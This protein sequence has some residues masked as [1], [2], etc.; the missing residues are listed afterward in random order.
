[1]GVFSAETYRAIVS[2]QRT[3]LLA[4]L[5]RGLLAAAEPIYGAVVARK[6]RRF[7]S[8]AK[9]ATQ[10]P[11]PVISVGNLTVGGTGKTPL[12]IWLAKWFRERGAQVAL[13]SRG[14][15]GRRA[16]NDEA[17]EIA[18]WL[19]DVPHLQ[20][21]DRV[22]SAR[23][24]LLEFP[25]SVLILDDAFQHRRIARNLDIVLLDALEPFGYGH[26][27]PR[28][29]LREPLESLTRAQIV[30]LSRSDAVSAERR[31][32][33]RGLVSR[34]APDAIWLE[35]THAPR[36]MID[37]Q[38]SAEPLSDWRGKRVAAF[39]GIGNPA[40]FQHTLDSCGLEVVA[41]RALAD[42]QAYD[43]GV[44]QSL[45]EWLSAQS[46]LAGVICTHKDLVKLPFAAI[47]DVPLRALK[48]ELQIASGQEQLERKLQE[49]LL[50]S[51]NSTSHTEAMI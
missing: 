1:M 6:N 15:G 43:P 18:A 31:A 13:L 5:I 49:V 4:M 28:G 12:V 8:G 16:P 41:F 40:G 47:G 2:G 42:H 33:I 26:L 27:L 22:A 21:A 45:S 51:A 9:L 48:I 11:T 29:L 50:A 25:G 14:Y 34:H 37:H 20:S 3:G 44:L 24:A 39:A 36:A 32:E 35:L 7:D 10:I 19:P 30:A 46:G 23:S 17:L 38:A